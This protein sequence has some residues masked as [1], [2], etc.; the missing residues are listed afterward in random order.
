MVSESSQTRTPRNFAITP[1]NNIFYVYENVLNISWLNQEHFPK[2]LIFAHLV[3]FCE[4]G[5]NEN[6]SALPHIFL[7]KIRVYIKMLLLLFKGQELWDKEFCSKKKMYVQI[8]H[9]DLED[10]I[11]Y[12]KHVRELLFSDNSHSHG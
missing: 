7:V 1:V 6:F 2:N 12:Y 9:K 11:T 8:F 3:R 4:V 5:C 10:S